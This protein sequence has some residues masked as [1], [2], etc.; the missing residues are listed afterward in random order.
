MEIKAAGIGW[1][2]NAWYLLPHYIDR[3]Y[4]VTIMYSYRSFTTAGV[5]SLGLA[6][7]SGDC[8]RGVIEF[9]ES[10]H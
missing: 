4:H 6:P 10:I 1:L 5:S 3:T 8:R 9:D 7:K 2:V